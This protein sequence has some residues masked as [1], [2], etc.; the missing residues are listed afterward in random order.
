MSNFQESVE[1]WR[2]SFRRI[3]RKHEE[4]DWQSDLWD[5]AFD[6]LA[7]T[8]SV[9]MSSDL[10]LDTDQLRGPFTQRSSSFLSRLLKCLKS[11]Y[12]GLDLI[13]EDWTWPCVGWVSLVTDRP[14]ESL[15]ALCFGRCQPDSHCDSQ[16][17]TCSTPLYRGTHLHSPQASRQFDWPWSYASF[18]L[19]QFSTQRCQLKWFY[20]PLDW[21]VIPLSLCLTF[22]CNTCSA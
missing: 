5:W 15:M 11:E 19:H 12:L 13:L 3:Q 14:F 7:L 4:L 17:L 22:L 8:I 10:F 2:H 9:S 16:T 20:A 1:L 18:C 21:H 6:S